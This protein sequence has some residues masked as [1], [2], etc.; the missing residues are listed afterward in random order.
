MP[1]KK[2]RAEQLQFLQENGPKVMRRVF[3]S[4]GVDESVRANLLGMSVIEYQAFSAGQPFPDTTETFRRFVEILSIWQALEVIFQNNNLSKM[5]VTTPN[6]NV[7]F[8]G[9]PPL[10]LMC[11]DLVG[12]CATRKLLDH[13]A[14]G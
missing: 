9:K 6:H 1:N 5:W 2:E 10:E 11:K 8:G 3:D 7:L 4:W 13:R 14:H 12:L